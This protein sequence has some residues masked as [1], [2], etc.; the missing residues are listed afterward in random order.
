[1][2]ELLYLQQETKYRNAIDSE[3]RV[4]KQSAAQARAAGN[5]GDRPLI[6]LTAGKPYDPDPLLSKEDMDK[7]NNMW[8]NVLQVGIGSTSFHARQT[9]RCAKQQSRDS[10]RAPG[11]CY[12]CDP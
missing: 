4:D 9:D 3:A 1:M 7:L 11:Y 2:E 10:L 5:M 12:F 6:V 8:I